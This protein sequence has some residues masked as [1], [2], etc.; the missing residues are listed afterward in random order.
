[1]TSLDLYNK[2]RE[3]KEEL[4]QAHDFF[5]SVVTPED[6]DL[7]IYKLIAAEKQ[8]DSLVRHYREQCQ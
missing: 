6:V 3:A 7:A 5:N 1:M 2:I 8:Y 4:Q